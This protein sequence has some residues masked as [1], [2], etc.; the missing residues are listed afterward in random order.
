MRRFLLSLITPNPGGWSYDDTIVI[1]LLLGALVLIV[2]SFIVRRIASRAQSGVM[3]KSLRTS[4]TAM[5]WFGIVAIVLTV[6][7]VEQIQF[8]AAQILW[9]VWGLAV[10]ITIAIQVRMTRSRY[11]EVLPRAGANSEREKYLPKAH[12][13]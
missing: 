9:V 5:L 6:A 4:A 1:A 8:L 11:A 12:R 7:R 3:R 10:I 2:G 13:R